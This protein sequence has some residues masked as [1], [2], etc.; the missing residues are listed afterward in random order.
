MSSRERLR[1]SDSDRERAATLLH[2]AAAEGRL[3]AEELDARLSAAFSA[4]TYGELD[5]LVDDL[6]TPVATPA[7]APPALVGFWRRFG[8]ALIDGVIVLLI[9]G[10]LS[11]A[12]HATGGVFGAV[13]SIAYFVFFEGGARGAGPGKQALGIQVVDAQTGGPIGYPRAFVRWVGRILSWLAFFIGYLW[14]LGDG[15]RQCWHDKLAGDLVVHSDGRRE[16]G[17]GRDVA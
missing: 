11:A 10:L 8:A 9:A 4:T 2:D 12:L 17:R 6:P 3:D 13:I 5:A 7:P 15:R 14:M 1:A 16:L